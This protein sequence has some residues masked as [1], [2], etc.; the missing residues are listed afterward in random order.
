MDY[1]YP[2][3]ISAGARA[4]IQRE[5]IVAGRELERRR[6]EARG[7]G[8]LE[9][10]LKRYV[11]RVFAAFGREALSLGRQGLWDVDRVE[12]EAREFLRQTVIRAYADKGV[13]RAGHRLHRLTGD[14]G[15]LRLEAQRELEASPEWG[16][17]QDGMLEVAERQGAEGQGTEVQKATPTGPGPVRLPVKTDLINKWMTEEGY[18]GKELAQKL[19]LS[20]RTVSSIRRNGP[21][22]GRKAVLKLATLMNR[23]EFDLYQS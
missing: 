11:L 18:T 10:E 9:T 23:D 1:P 12:R 5:E 2:Q 19:G 7:P 17:F 6:L 22:H 4:R 20:E 21:Y 13:D 3:E 8:E 16:Q 15:Y 14:F